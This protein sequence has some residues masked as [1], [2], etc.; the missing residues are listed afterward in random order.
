L[1]CS[2]CYQ[3]ALTDLAVDADYI[4]TVSDTDDA[5]A[6]SGILRAAHYVESTILEQHLLDVAFQKAPVGM[7]LV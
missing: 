5:K 4:P 1:S 7:L 6:H 2:Y 3:D